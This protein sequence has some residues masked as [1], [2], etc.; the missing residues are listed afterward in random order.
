MSEPRSLHA[1]TVGARSSHPG[2]RRQARPA[3]SLRSAAGAR[4][5]AVLPAARSGAAAP[6]SGP[7]P[8]HCSAPTYQYTVATA[9]AG[10]TARALT[11]AS[12]VPGTAGYVASTV[13]SHRAGRAGRADDASSSRRVTRHSIIRPRGAHIHMILYPDHHARI[14][15]QPGMMREEKSRIDGTGRDREGLARLPTANIPPQRHRHHHGDDV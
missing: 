15:G 12:C 10:R 1:P 4:A 9:L 8:R 7:S 6:P 11:A 13:G 5:P 14:H 2:C 3:E